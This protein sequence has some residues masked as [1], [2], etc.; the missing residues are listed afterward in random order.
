VSLSPDYSGF[1]YTEYFRIWIDLNQ[2]GSYANAERLFNGTQG[3]TSAMTGTIEIPLTAELGSVRMRVTM[4][5][6]NGFP[7][8]SCDDLDYGEVEDYCVNILEEDPINP[9]INELSGIFGMEAFPIPATNILSIRTLNLDKAAAN[10]VIMDASGRVVSTIPSNGQ[11][12]Q[13]LEVSQL[14]E[15]VYLVE[16]HDKETQIIGRTRFVKQ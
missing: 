7:N 4:T 11:T 6:G 14:A 15:G 2:N 13:Q 9:G 8:N 10:V 16:L 3:T 12:T 1:A 5:D